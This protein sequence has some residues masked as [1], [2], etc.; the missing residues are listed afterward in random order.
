MLGPLEVWRDGEALE[1]RGA[2][3]RALLALLILHANEVVR[4]DRL[5]DDLWGDE[6]PSNAQAA[7][8]NHIS[9]LRKDLGGEVL[10]TKPWGY[11]LRTGPD[12]VDLHRFERLVEE[13]R[14]LAARGRRERLAE[15]LALWRGPALADLAQEPALASEIDRLEEL[16]L[17]ALEERIDADLELGLSSELVGELEGLVAEHPLRERLRGQLIVALYRG[18]RQAEAL[19]TYRETRRLLVEELGIEPGP[20]LRALE[21]AILRQDPTLAVVVA[22]APELVSEEQPPPSSQWRWPRSPLVLATMLA[23]LGA[24][25]AIAAMFTLRNGPEQTLG[26]TSRVTSPATSSVVATGTT[27]T[28][29]RTTSTTHK[30]PVVPATTTQAAVTRRITTTTPHPATT[31]APHPATTTAPQPATTTTARPTTATRVSHTTPV[32]TN[33]DTVD[34][35]PDGPPL[36]SDSFNGPLDSTVWQSYTAGQGPTVSQQNGRVEIFLPG[37]AVPYGQYAQIMGGYQTVCR[38]PSDFDARLDYELLDWPVDDYVNVQLAAYMSNPTSFPQVIRQSIGGS[39]VYVGA[40]PPSLHRG[41]RTSDRS[42]RLRIARRDG[43]FS[44]YYWE[45]ADN[46]WILLLSYEIRG[47]AAINWGVG[48]DGKV[49]PRE[50]VRVIFD[51]AVVYASRSACG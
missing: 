19:E 47:V 43:V 34:R 38:F 10:V 22:R 1:L 33:A 8:Q 41:I 21:R 25:G 51:N 3:R 11:V 46:R 18:G 26:A 2:K 17:A 15:A 13:S 30:K 6:R 35:Q 28:E 31:T 37:D 36:I 40:Y 32:V 5:I 44:T 23:L 48:T 4:T 50:D 42:G 20:E 27:T 29:H 24:L 49:T 16:R 9:R 12:D 14:P 39:E 7:L 45:N